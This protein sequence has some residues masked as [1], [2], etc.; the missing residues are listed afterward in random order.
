MSLS[1][2]VVESCSDLLASAAG[3]SIASNPRNA[4]AYAVFMLTLSLGLRKMEIKVATCK[5]VFESQ[6]I[7]CEVPPVT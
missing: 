2:I 4:S 7:R 3:D 5:V 1:V 6:L